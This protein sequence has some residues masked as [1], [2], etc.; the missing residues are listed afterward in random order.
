MVVR[1]ALPADPHPP[2]S[3][4]DGEGD[5]IPP[6]P[7]FRLRFTP[8]D[9]VELFRLSDDDVRRMEEERGR[10]GGMLTY[11]YARWRMSW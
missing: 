1:N 10:W 11:E 2:G 5:M 7:V 8:R 4:P 3:A 9:G 6:A